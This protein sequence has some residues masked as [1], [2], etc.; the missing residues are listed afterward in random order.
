MTSDAVEEESGSA[1]ARP[2]VAVRRRR[3]LLFATAA[4]AVVAATVFAV[5]RS[6]D[7]QPPPPD[8][9]LDAWAP[10]WTIQDSLD[11]LA[12]H[13]DLLRQVSPFGYQVTGASTITLDPNASADEMASLVDAGRDAGAE[14]IPSIR[15][16][17]PAGAMAEILADP[18]TR[19][20]HVGAIVDFV[21]E[22]SFDG[23][24]VNYEQFAFA[25]AR[26]SW[27]ETRPNWVT[28]VRELAAALGDHTLVV[29]VPPV[30]DAGTGPDSGYWVYDYAAIAPLVDYVRVMAYDHSFDQPGP[31]APLQWVGRVVDGAIDASGTPDKLVLGVPLYG[32]NW[33]VS[34]TGTCPEGEDVGR[35]TV[36]ARNVDEL[37]ELRS[38][39]PVY[40]EL[41]GE[42]SFTYTLELDDGSTSCRQL[43]EVHY[44][45][46][47]GARARVD[48]ARRADLGGASL[49]ALGYDD[50][51]VWVELAE[52]ARPATVD[53][54]GASSTVAPV[55]ND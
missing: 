35:T 39:T 46:A 1:P 21:E 40:D 6:G 25:D 33:R 43:R 28:F 14:V 34:T 26:A 27:A 17:T 52:L 30:Y 31:I 16:A 11:V 9:P 50:D 37:I 15:D 2:S 23:V 54:P 32:Y 18:A 19:R 4:V 42:W 24:D 22:G 8:V 5:V 3:A 53:G 44:V 29:S 41:T 20:A 49:W 51:D 7:D 12:D 13:G 47:S 36:T 38:V 45:D 10:Y 55:Q 48:I